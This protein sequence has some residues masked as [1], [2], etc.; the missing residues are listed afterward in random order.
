MTEEDLADLPEGENAAGVPG[1]EATESAAPPAESG[2]RMDIKLDV[3]EGPLDLLLHLVRKEKL[4]IYDIPISRITTQ[5]LEYLDLMKTLNVNVASEFLAMAATLLYIKSRMLLPEAFEEDEED[6]R[7]DLMRR[8]LEHQLYKEAAD[9]LRGLTMLGRDAFTH[10]MSPEELEKLGTLEGE[11]EAGFFDLLNA[12][13]DAQKKFPKE[14]HHDVELEPMTIDQK[15][16][17][18]S[19]WMETKYEL[20]LQELFGWARNRFELVLTFIAVLEL[21]RRK[22]IVALQSEAFGAVRIRRRNNGTPG[23]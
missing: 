11:I 6:P 2:P 4:N 23:H 12:Y 20:D 19:L 21:V 3:F 22:A 8:L 17:Q 18:I 16:E 1:A 7:E 10:A 15:I 13:H 14:L 5:Y 9:Q